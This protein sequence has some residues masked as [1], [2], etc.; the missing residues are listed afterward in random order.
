M[1]FGV[2]VAVVVCVSCIK[3]SKEGSEDDASDTRPEVLGEV[4]VEVEAEVEAEVEVEVEVEVTPTGPIAFDQ[5]RLGATWQVGSAQ[6]VRLV[7][8]PALET[9]YPGATWFATADVSIDGGPFVALDDGLARTADAARIIRWN[10]TAPAGGEL[11]LRAQLTALD[12]AAA[13]LDVSALGSPEVMVSLAPSGLRACYTWSLVTAD[14]AFAPRDGPGALVKDG[15]MWLLGGWNPLDPEHFPEIT[16]N[17]VWSSADGLTWREDVPNGST[18]L[19]SRRHKAGYAVFDDALW[20]LGGDLSTGAMQ[21]DVWRSPDG[22][23]W[24]EVSAAAPWGQRVLHMVWVHDGALWVMGGQTLPQF[25]GP[26]E[27]R[28][29]NDVWRSR[30]GADWE[31]VLEHAPWS[32]RGMMGGEA[33]HRGRMWL[34][35]GGTYDMP[36]LPARRYERD[37]WSSHDGITWQHDLIEAPW[38]ARQYHE[39]AVW[40]GRLF[41]LE[42]YDGLGNRAD[43]WY[44]DDGVSWYELVDTPWAPRHAAAVFVHDGALWMVTGNNL[45]SDVWRL[46]CP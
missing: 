2:L 20:V 45:T 31:L 46:D 32:P 17:D 35:G 33:V 38:A 28:L 16:V 34:L 8:D 44:S 18:D 11:R 6:V 42:G 12:P 43:V 21:P 24:R 29:Y 1:R 7:V 26:A 40:D 4:E 5:P 13:P 37:V 41:V 9:S 22:I 23:T 14:A 25:G 19:W 39:V 30:D 27:A 36:E 10:L 15:R 3:S